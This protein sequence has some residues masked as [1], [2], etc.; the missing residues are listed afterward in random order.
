[1]SRRHP[2]RQRPGHIAVRTRRACGAGPPA[3]APPRPRALCGW[4]G[5]TATTPTTPT[6]A[7]GP[8]GG[9]E[10]ARTSGAEPTST[11]TARLRCCCR[12]P[13]VRGRPAT[14]VGQAHPLMS[15]LAEL[16]WVCVSIN[17]RLS[18]RNTWPDHIVDVKQAIGWVKDNIGRYGGD[19]DFIAIT[20]GFG[21][22]P[23]FLARRAHPESAAVSTGIRRHGHDRAGCD[24]VLRR[25]RLHRRRRTAPG[26]AAVRR[27]HRHEN[28][29]GAMLNAVHGCRAHHLCRTSSSTLLRAAWPQRRLHPRQAGERL[30][31]RLREVSTQPVVGT[32]N[33]LWHNMPSTSWDRH[34]RRT[35]QFEQFLAEIYA[36]HSARSERVISRS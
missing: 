19:P 18:P 8:H 15:H 25:L 30:R 4:C 7:H 2:L 34:A 32:P 3:V 20:G 36:N 16:G 10:P 26:H 12:F 33:S 27:G 11:A 22:R 23:P 13:V 14:S 28:F 6:S 5:S 21:R 29:S 17:Y 31:P 24:P 1:M 35:R 9:R